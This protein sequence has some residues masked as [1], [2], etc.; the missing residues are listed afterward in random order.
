MDGAT[1]WIPRLHG[2]HG[3]LRYCGADLA[4]R[5]LLFPVAAEID[6]RRIG[7]TS[8][9]NVSDEAI[10]LR[11]IYVLPE[12]RAMGVG[13]RLAAF[14]CG[15]F[16]PPWR[17]CLIYARAANVA[18]YE[19]WGFAVVPGHAPRSSELD[20]VLPDVTVVLMARSLPCA[21]ATSPGPATTEFEGI[22][23][24]A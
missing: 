7:W 23:T 9:Y 2:G 22:P 3:Q 19:R 1:R 13:R 15:L 6:G 5:V 10:R 4:E 16:P 24:P 12:F 14:A 8:A 11:G 20:R 21:A 17:T 18:L